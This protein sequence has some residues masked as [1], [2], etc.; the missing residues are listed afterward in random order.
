VRDQVPDEQR[1]ELSRSES[2]KSL[3][4]S[5]G[6]LR[7]GGSQWE[8]GCIGGRRLYGKGMGCLGDERE[9]M[10]YEESRRERGVRGQELGVSWRIWYNSS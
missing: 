3:S 5:F 2:R 10:R 7:Q 4:R 6:L 9:G 8:A 1:E